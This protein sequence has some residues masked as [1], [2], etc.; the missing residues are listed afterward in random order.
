[1]AIIDFE[2]EHKGDKERK[3]TK[4]DMK[5]EIINRFHKSHEKFFGYKINNELVAYI[6]LKPFFPGHK[7]CEI[8]WLAVKKKY[9][10][11]GIGTKLINFIC[12]LSKKMNFRK[13][14]VY[15]GKNMNLTKKFYEKNGFKLINEFKEYYGFEIGDTTAVL[16][17]KKLNKPK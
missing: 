2:S 11:M 4:K 9:Q 10:N 12:N 5:K 15:T 17:G 16:Y 13:V 14:F 8:Y 6:T 3:V 7:H 1:M